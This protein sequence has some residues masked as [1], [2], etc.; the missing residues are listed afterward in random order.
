[1]IATKAAKRSEAMRELV[2]RTIDAVRGM[3]PRLS[4]KALDGLG[5][6]DALERLAAHFEGRPEI[7]CIF[8]FEDV[9]V[10]HGPI[11]AA[12]YR[13]AQEALANVARHGARASRS[14][15]R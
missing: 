13:I 2:Y 5:L 11:A 1:M 3:A 8:N 6:V 12:A 15:S 4:P 7:N 10:I 9:P 14:R